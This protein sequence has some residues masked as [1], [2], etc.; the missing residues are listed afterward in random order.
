MLRRAPKAV[1]IR[2]EG[3]RARPSDRGLPS[4]PSRSVADV[5]DDD[6][7]RRCAMKVQAGVQ[8]CREAGPDPARPDDWPRPRHRRS[9]GRR[10]PRDVELAGSAPGRP[11]AARP[12]R[13]SGINTPILPSQT[14]WIKRY[15]GGRLSFDPDPSSPGDGRRSSAMPQTAPARRDARNPSTLGPEEHLA[16]TSAPT[17]DPRRY[18]FELPATPDHGAPGEGIVL[19]THA[20]KSPCPAPKAHGHPASRAPVISNQQPHCNPMHVQSPPQMGQG[21]L[22]KVGQGVVPTLYH[23][24]TLPTLPNRPQRPP[25]IPTAQ[26]IP[27]PNPT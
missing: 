22:S 23:D 20:Y 10:Q 16:D 8:G 24:P 3:W 7:R 26:P 18:W 27:C 1:R 5:N 25:P 11:W 14:R 17:R 21:R 9:A 15:S 4:H 12:R 6:S 2:P 13:R 19:P